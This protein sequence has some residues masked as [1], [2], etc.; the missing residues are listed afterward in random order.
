MYTI[1]LKPPADFQPTVRVAGC[2]CSNG[3]EFLLVL[4][5]PDKPQGGTWGLPAGKLEQG[6]EPRVA[7][8]RELFEEVGIRTDPMLL[9]EVCKIYIRLDHTDY[10]FY[11]FHQE[12]NKKPPIVLEDAH[13]EARWV[14]IAEALKLPL[15]LGATEIIDQYQQYL[16]KG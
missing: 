16:R 1:Y 7:A 13:P 6:E 12:F 11:A 10:I 4:R 8:S 9:Q 2:F 14:T 3:D 5:H 15:I